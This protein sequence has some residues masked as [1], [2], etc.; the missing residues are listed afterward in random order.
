MTGGSRPLGDRG[1]MVYPRRD[2]RSDTMRAAVTFALDE[3]E[4][5]VYPARM[6]GM[7][8]GMSRA[9]ELPECLRGVDHAREAVAIVGTPDPA[10][11]GLPLALRR[12]TE[13]YWG[14]YVEPLITE[15]W[16]E[17]RSTPFY[18]KFQIGAQQVYAPAPYTVA[19]I[20]ERRPLVLRGFNALCR[21]L[22]LPRSALVLG[23][24]LF[25]PTFAALV[26]RRENRRI[27]LMAAFIALA[28]EAFDH[29]LSDVPLAGRP[30][31]LRGVLEGTVEPPNAPFRLL[32]AIVEALYEGTEGEEREEL[33]RALDGCARWGEAEVRRARGEPDPTGYQ[34]RMIGILTGIDGLAWTVRRHITPA[35]RDWMYSVSEFIQILDDW[36][37]AEKD[38]REGTITPVHDGTWTAETIREHYEHTTR[39]VG[40]IV[41]ENG[42]RYGAYVALAE[43]AYRF[44]VADLLGNMVTGVAD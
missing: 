27:S 15:H 10:A 41:R 38:F 40:Q 29:H 24:K 33:R 22:R 5:L 1:P 37:D 36:V 2:G 43:E 42:E 32:R 13:R 19:V 17:V 39:T 11:S 23:L 31:I 28:D 16:P 35:E 14:R 7:F 12:E 18:K 6:P 8:Q 9:A 30:R 25:I 44:Q 3:T 34:H 4:P 21:A 20:S 26:L